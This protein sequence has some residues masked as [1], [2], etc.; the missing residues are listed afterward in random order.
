MA[1][2]SRRSA[3]AHS[4]TLELLP[5]VNEDTFMQ[6]RRISSTNAAAISGITQLQFKGYAE[7]SHCSLGRC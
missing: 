4:F 7:G 3:T 5:K 6:S 1:L 2:S